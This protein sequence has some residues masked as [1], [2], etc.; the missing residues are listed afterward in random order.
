MSDSV[1]RPEQ[2]DIRVLHGVDVLV[3]VVGPGVPCPRAA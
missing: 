3:V 2:T 1:A